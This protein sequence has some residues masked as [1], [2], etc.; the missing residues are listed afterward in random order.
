M[1][2]NITDFFF[3][4]FTDQYESI[5][6]SSTKQDMREMVMGNPLDME[7]LRD[8]CWDI[9]EIHYG[10]DKYS[11]FHQ[12]VHASIDFKQLKASLKE[13]LDTEEA[14]ENAA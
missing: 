3:S 13:W 11:A 1:D 7:P 2:P 8:Y 5:D 6:E 4:M 14:T 9:M 12:A 10:A